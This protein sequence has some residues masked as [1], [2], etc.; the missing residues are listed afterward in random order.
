M[1]HRVRLNRSELE[2]LVWEGA[3]RDST[4]KRVDVSGLD[5][6]HISLVNAKFVDCD[7]R[8]TSLARANLRNVR[9]DECALDGMSAHRAA[10]TGLIVSLAG[11]SAIDFSDADLREAEFFTWSE[12]DG[13]LRGSK[14][15]FADLW[16]A[17]LAN[18]DLSGSSLVDTN[19]AGCNLSRARMVGVDA[20]WVNCTGAVLTGAVLTGDWRAARLDD[21]LLARATLSDDGVAINLRGASLIGADAR[22]AV[23]DGADMT[24]ADATG[25]NFAWAYLHKVEATNAR[26]SRVD[27]Q[28]ASVDSADFTGSDFG[29]A[30]RIAIR[31]LESANLQNT[32]T[33]G[34]IDGDTSTAKRLIPSPTAPVEV[35]PATAR[36]DPF[37]PHLDPAATG[38]G[39]SMHI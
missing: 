22:E 12:G 5:L 39:P 34:V 20:R 8:A 7:F 37:A 15:D 31:G 13:D 14:F 38:T 29:N 19:L 25:A 35:K 1:S 32:T 33:T 28:H 11:Q 23:F 10:A 17:E 36:V 16:L 9:F 26:F 30:N 6:S 4:I 27:L 18:V 21:A 2:S 3:V 24:N